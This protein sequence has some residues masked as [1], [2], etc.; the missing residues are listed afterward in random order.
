MSVDAHSL[1]VPFDVAH[2]GLDAVVEDKAEGALHVDPAAD[3]DECC[4]AST[5]TC[6]HD[7]EA[8]KQ[9]SVHAV[10]RGLGLVPVRLSVCMGIAHAP[11]TACDYNNA[12]A[13]GC[14]KHQREVLA[15]LRRALEGEVDRGVCKVDGGSA[16]RAYVYRCCPSERP[17]VCLSHPMAT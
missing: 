12:A 6:E 16:G 1:D 10:V 9:G 2:C 14:R 11:H 7:I 17:R 4:V 3:G 15:L 8:D 5:G 13:T